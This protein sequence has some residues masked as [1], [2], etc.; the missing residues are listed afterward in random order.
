M[1]LGIGSSFYFV[2]STNEAKWLKVAEKLI[3]HAAED[4]GCGNGV[5]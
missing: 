1:L 4:I 2:V 3:E 5:D